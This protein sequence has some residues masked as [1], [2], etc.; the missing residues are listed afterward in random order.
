MHL[1][2][3]FASALSEGLQ[4]TLQT[5][6]LPHLAQL[7]AL[8]RPGERV[9]IDEYTLTP[10][11]ERALAELSGWHGD[12][13]CLPWAAQAAQGDGLET[14]DDA[15]GLLTP[16]HWHVGTEFV[17][18]TD[19]QAL[20]L[21]ADESRQ[22]F[23]SIRELFE[24]EGWSLVWA[25]PD[26]WYAAHDSLDG[27]PSASLDRVVGRNI[28]L[29]L[30]AHPQARLIRRL[31]NEVQMALYQ[32]PLHDERVARGAL[33]VNS[34]W[35]SGCGRAQPVRAPAELV[36]DARLKAPALAEHA[37]AW[38]NAWQ[39][40]DAGPVAELLARARTGQPATLTLCG[41]RHAQRFA[42]LVE[43]GW[44]SRTTARWRA[45][46]SA[47]PVLEGL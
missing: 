18:L 45:A 34:F 4:R 24:S 11:H 13:G 30:P 5:L 37:V 2:I 7:L 22:A 6:A 41:E 29:W 44:W 40:L 19:P 23:D 12:D 26:R 28:D 33:P 42:G 43:R 46:P 20:A 9:G 27:L 3:P 8:L 31:Q 16:V 32:Q 38:A 47:V 21:G 1:F 14:G 15:W 17:T 35:L 39:D 10:P 36:V 25:A